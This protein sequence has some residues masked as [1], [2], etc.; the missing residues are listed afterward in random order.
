VEYFDHSVIITMFN[1]NQRLFNLVRR[2]YSRRTVSQDVYVGKPDK[3][4]N[5]R[6]LVVS[7]TVSDTALQKRM[8]DM[9]EETQKWH[10]NF[11]AEHNRKY[12]KVRALLVLCLH[13]NM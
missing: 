2:A 1:R 9:R 4:S 13:K 12:N 11:W 3:Q 8:N 10:H 7:R 5:I 6:P